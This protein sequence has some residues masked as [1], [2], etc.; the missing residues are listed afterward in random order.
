[1]TYGNKCFY[2]A[3]YLIRHKKLKAINNAMIFDDKVSKI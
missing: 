1:M 2:F 3:L